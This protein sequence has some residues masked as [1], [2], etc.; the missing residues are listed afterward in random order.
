[1]VTQDHVGQLTQWRRV[2]HRF[3]FLNIKRRAEDLAVGQRLRQRCRID[4]RA[5]RGIDEARDG[6]LVSGRLS[7]LL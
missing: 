6:A 7:A 4:Q 5:T 1:V 2:G 3:D